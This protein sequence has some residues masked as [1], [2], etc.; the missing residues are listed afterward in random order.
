MEIMG[1]G[2]PD[3]MHEN[4]GEWFSNHELSCRVRT[5]LILGACLSKGIQV[6]PPR[7]GQ[8]A[9]LPEVSMR[10]RVNDFFVP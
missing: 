7:E 1:S 8:V 6:H 2:L 10:P 5:G 9:Q 4:V 3:Q